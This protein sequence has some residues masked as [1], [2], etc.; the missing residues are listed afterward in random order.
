M[1]TSEAF[2][3]SHGGVEWRT[4]YDLIGD[5]T[6]MDALLLPAPSSVSTRT[7]MYGLARHLKRD[8][9]CIVVDWPGFGGVRGPQ[10]ELTPNVLRE[11]LETFVGTVVRRPALLIAAGHSAAYAMSAARAHP[12]VFTHILL[13][14]PTWRGPL[15]TAMG[16]NRRPLWSA[17]RRWIERPVVGPLIYKL[18]VNRVV[19]RRM[20]KAHVYAD[21][22]FITPELLS[23]KTRITERPRARF[24]TAAFVTGGLDLVHERA[25]FH[26]LFAPSPAARV[27][28]L[29]GDSTPTKSRAEMDALVKLHGV[30]SE[31]APGSLALHEE[32]PEAV[33]E[34][35]KRL[36]S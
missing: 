2:V 7:E 22:S 25:S 34:A 28:V 29:I 4:D 16:D 9:R 1:Q 33:V 23:D 32:F 27:K 8:F 5:D 20:L 10:A 35:A 21:P 30:E 14:A 17:I 36:V 26:R 18:N 15:P 13:T 24:A 12:H 19:V 31:I 3:W 11:F 6:S